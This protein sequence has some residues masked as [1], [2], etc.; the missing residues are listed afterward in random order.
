MAGQPA[1]PRSSSPASRGG[2]VVLVLEHGVELGESLDRERFAQ[3]SARLHAGVMR[4][5]RGPWEPPDW[6]ESVRCGI[7]LLILEGLVLRQIEIGGRVAAELLSTGDLLRPWQREDSIASLP[8]KPRWRALERTRVAVLDVDFTRRL[9][10]FP[11]L[12]GELVG[13]ALR[14][15]RQLAVNVAIVHQPRVEVRVQM[16]LWQLADRFGTV[17]QSGVLLP[18]RLT[19]TLIAELVAA[20]RPTVSAALSSLERAGEVSRS[21]DGG[22]LLHGSPPGAAT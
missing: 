5:G 19:H 15:S 12:E 14:R 3:A 9:A 11:E 16:M 18:L 20:R 22:W 8:R 13:R 6:P 7:G 10:P 21:P 2:R 4:I 1:A 17:T